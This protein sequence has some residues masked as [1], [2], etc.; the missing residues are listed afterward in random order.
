MCNYIGLSCRNNQ[1]AKEINTMNGKIP[2]LTAAC[3]CSQK[4]D[5]KDTRDRGVPE[6]K[7]KLSDHLWLYRSDLSSCFCSSGWS[8]PFTDSWCSLCF[9]D[10]SY[11]RLNAISWFTELQIIKYLVLIRFSK[12]LF[13]CLLM[14]FFLH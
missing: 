1:N 9:H 4:L 2:S 11:K 8:L 10:I 13:M 7:N 3:I 6:T 14:I 12:E 5:L